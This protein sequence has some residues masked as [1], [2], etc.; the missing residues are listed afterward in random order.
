MILL[1]FLVC[2][3]RRILYNRVER[4]MNMKDHNPEHFISRGWAL[5]LE[6]LENSV[7]MKKVGT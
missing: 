6:A 7:A 2:V 3:E 4:E 1:N 5:P